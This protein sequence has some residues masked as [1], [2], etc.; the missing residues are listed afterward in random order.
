MV[1]ESIRRI[2]TIN[3]GSSSLRADCYQVGQG[4]TLVFSAEAERIGLPGT[5]LWIADANG[6]SLQEQQDDRL[7]HTAAIEAVFAWLRDH[8]AQRELDAVGHRVVHG[9]SRYSEPQPI[10]PT[11]VQ[12]IEELVPIDPDHLPQALAA[13]RFVS[14]TYPALLQVA[15]FDTAFHRHMPQVAQAY[16]LPRHLTDAGLARLARYGFHG[17][18]YEYIMEQLRTEAATAADGRVIIA[19]LGNG[20]SMAAVREGKSVDTTMGFTPTGGLVMSTRSGDLDPGVLLYLL[21]EQQLT[22]AA[23]GEL[24]NKQSGLLGVSGSSGDMR[25]LVTRQSSDADAAAAV[26]LFCYQARKFLGA[27]CTTLGGLDTLVFTAG[28]GEH[29]AEIRRR[30]C[31]GLQF[32][33]IVLDPDRNQAHA[34]IISRELSGVFVRVMHTDENR[35]IARHAAQL[36]KEQGATHVSV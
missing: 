24:V 7:D 3:T 21:Q 20:A 15:C 4:E 16:A 32:L 2:L 5:R 34:P 35:M 14:Q 23:L 25:D 8:G 29:Q 11:L 31:D 36:I 27:L 30:I 12:S 18:S 6:T 19:H 22:P 13:M 1:R 17:L 33:G 9:G 26:E 28:I 10:T